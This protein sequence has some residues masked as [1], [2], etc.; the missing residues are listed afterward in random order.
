MIKEKRKRE[1]D[2][3]ITRLKFFAYMI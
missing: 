1:W 3:D 2:T